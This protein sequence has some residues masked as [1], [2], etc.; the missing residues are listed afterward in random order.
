M[1]IAAGRD[2]CPNPARLARAHVLPDG[3]CRA[4]DAKAREHVGSG[5]VRCCSSPAR[6]TPTATTPRRDPSTAINNEA[7]KSPASRADISGI[8]AV[9]RPPGRRGRGD[10]IP[11]SSPGKA[12]R[13][14]RSRSPRSARY[15]GAPNRRSGRNRLVKPTWATSAAAGS[16]V[17]QDDPRDAP[18]RHPAHHQ[19]RRA[20]RRSTSQLTVPLVTADTVEAN[21][22][23]ARGPH[24]FASA[25]QRT[26]SSK[27]PEPRRRAGDPQHQ[28]AVVARTPS[29]MEN[30]TD[31]ADT[32]GAAACRR[33][34]YTRGLGA[35][36]RQCVAS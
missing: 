9:P 23:R 21:G 20:N 29:A 35:S 27:C 31:G 3:H 15:R 36:V 11:S 17:G 25:V 32:C 13:A 2:Y 5:P 4:F 24:S 18:Q 8:A 26:L 34:R 28:P 1:A 30:R 33:H 10:Q 19:L 6:A 14:T 12:P 16:P 7:T 22:T